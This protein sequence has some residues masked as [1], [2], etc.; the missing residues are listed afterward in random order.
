M[1]DDIGVRVVLIH[2]RR[3]WSQKELSEKTVSFR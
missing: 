1:R 3:G 2:T